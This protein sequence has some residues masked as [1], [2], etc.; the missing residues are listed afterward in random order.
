[1]SAVISKAR[2]GFFKTFL[3]IFFEASSPFL[4]RL[5]KISPKASAAIVLPLTVKD[6]FLLHTE[7]T[8]EYFTNFRGYI[9]INV[10]LAD[11]YIP[12]TQYE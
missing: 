3:D 4:P 1:M 2:A 6:I 12:P 5:L 11:R 8:N 9:T 10:F 7:K